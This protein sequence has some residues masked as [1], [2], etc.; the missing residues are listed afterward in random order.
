MHTLYSAIGYLWLAAVYAGTYAMKAAQDGAVGLYYISGIMNSGSDTPALFSVR[1]LL[2]LTPP[3]VLYVP[4]AR[5]LSPAWAR[6]YTAVWYLAVFTGIQPRV[7]GGEG[8]V[9]LAYSHYGATVLVMLYTVAALWARGL[10]RL[11]AFWLVAGSVYGGLFVADKVD[12][13]PGVPDGLKVVEAV[14]Y[15][16]AT[17]AFLFIPTSAAPAEAPLPIVAVSVPVAERT[18]A[19]GRR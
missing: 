7:F 16:S 13:L 14:F 2:W 15:F 9:A 6:G 18:A 17:A 3:L 4:V 11:G 8:N 19:R 5:A 12:P 1:L 10:R